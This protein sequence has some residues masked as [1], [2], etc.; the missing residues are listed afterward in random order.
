[1]YGLYI[2]GYYSRMIEFIDMDRS[3]PK[4][5]SHV[6]D[7]FLQ[8]AARM[9]EQIDEQTYASVKRI[10]S[11]DVL[12]TQEVEDYEIFNENKSSRPLIQ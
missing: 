11:K 6:I 8:I 2:Q 4:L 5:D 1:M 3:I 10:F 9:E 12:M 7:Y